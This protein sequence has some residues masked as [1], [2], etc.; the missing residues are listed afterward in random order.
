[1][2]SSAPE[3]LV[4]GVL[5]LTEPSVRSLVERLRPRTPLDNALEPEAVLLPA[6]HAARPTSWLVRYVFALVALDALAMSL[7][8]VFAL[9]MRFGAD[10]LATVALGNGT[11]YLQLVALAVPCWGL[12]L[13]ARRAYE[14]RYLGVG[15]EEFRRVTN[16][17]LLFTSVFA[18]VC[19]AFDL[20]PARLVVAVALPLASV[21]TSVLRYAARTVLH[22]CRRDGQ[23]GHRVLV[24][25]DAQDAEV[26]VDRLARSPH[27]GLASWPPP[28]HG[29]AR[30][31]SRRWLTCR[32]W[33][34]SSGSTRSRWLTRPG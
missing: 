3:V 14:P 1:M 33:W 31:A 29:R 18:I 32:G 8:G 12:V 34:P 2:S 16:A 15:S 6:A 27:A 13:S 20:Q 11:T 5:D 4:D 7:A 30:T 10:G 28:G 9:T 23:A 24:V 25:A 19:V 22:R 26:L 21:L 17:S